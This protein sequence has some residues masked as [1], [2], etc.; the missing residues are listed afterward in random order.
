MLSRRDLIVG[1][2]AAGLAPRTAFA[3]PVANGS[4]A[5]KPALLRAALQ[6]YQSHRDRLKFHDY[7]GIADFSAASRLPRFH[8]LDLAS[9]R[10]RACL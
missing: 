8:I 3:A 2:A 1:G 5:I 10:T 9:R 4:G 7:I 6:S